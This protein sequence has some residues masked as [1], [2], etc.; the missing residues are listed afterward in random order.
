MRLD[1]AMGTQDS[2]TPTPTGADGRNEEK[3]Y[4]TKS[5]SSFTSMI[6]EGDV[7]MLNSYLQTF[8]QK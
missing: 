8:L 5:F 4:N 7:R 6:C 3:V 1:H 2:A